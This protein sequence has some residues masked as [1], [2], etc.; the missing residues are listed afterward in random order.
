MKKYFFILLFA[1]AS[2][3]YS[4]ADVITDDFSANAFGWTECAVES[5]NGSSVIDKGCLTI[6]SKGENKGLGAMLTALNGV[7]TKVGENTSFETHCYAPLNVQHDFKI[8]A[9]VKID[10]LGSD[11]LVGFLFNYKDDGNFYCFSFNDEM[12]NF[13]RWV[14]GHIVGGIKQSMKWKD[15]SKVEQQ[16]TLQKEGDELVF[17]VDN[18]EVIRVR[19]MIIE[20]SGVGFWTFGKQTLVVYEMQYQQ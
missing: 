11:R 8:V 20:Y 13:Q 4:F 1:A 15:R 6:K 12:V 2:S 16:W 17:F 10:K 9:N 14:D 5:S 3:F 19:Y 18:I 7:K